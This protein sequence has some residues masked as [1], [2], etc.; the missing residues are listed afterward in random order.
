M[1]HSSFTVKRKTKRWPSIIFFNMV[2]LAGS[3]RVVWSRAFPTNRYDHQ[4]NTQ[5]FLI[6]VAKEVVFEQVKRRTA[7]TKTVSL[8]Y[9]LNL[10]AVLESL[11][12]SCDHGSLITK[13]KTS[14]VYCREANPIKEFNTFQITSFSS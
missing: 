3:S 13:K 9:R 6:Q 11:T 8:P 4:D 12:A 10:E 5:A 1:A 14:N 7:A 2:D